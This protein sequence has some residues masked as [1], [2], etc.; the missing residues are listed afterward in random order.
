MNNLKLVTT[1]M[2]ENSV[3]CDFW[4]DVND[5][6]FITIALQCFA[7]VVEQLDMFN[8]FKVNGV[9]NLKKYVGYDA[10]QGWTYKYP[11]LWN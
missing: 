4:K 5:E 2:F 3:S 6:Y 9:D 1:E 10:L 8:K 11:E 7:G